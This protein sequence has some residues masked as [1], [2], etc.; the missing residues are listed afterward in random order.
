M[1]AIPS[2]TISFLYNVLNDPVMNADFRKNPHN[3]ME[4]FQLSDAQRKLIED[5]GLDLLKLRL[6]KDA[7]KEIERE[8]EAARVEKNQPSK[9]READILNQKVEASLKEIKFFKDTISEVEVRKLSKEIF[10]KEY[11][12]KMKK[13]ICDAI[14]EEL[15][16]GYG[17]FW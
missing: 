2:G 10:E 9:P 16:K 11:Q 12:E 13:L 14:E 6:Q 1:A 5:I 3:V 4:F 8:K 15:K 17:H 7:A